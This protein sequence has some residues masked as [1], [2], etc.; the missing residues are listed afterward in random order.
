MQVLQENWI[1]FLA[2]WRQA[3]QF[4]K[5][6]EWSILSFL[7]HQGYTEFWNVVTRAGFSQSPN[8]FFPLV[9]LLPKSGAM[10][11]EIHGKARVPLASLQINLPVQLIPREL[12]QLSLK[13]SQFWRTWQQCP[14]PLGRVQGESVGLPAPSHDGNVSQHV[15][16]QCSAWLLRIFFH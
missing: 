8:L 12:G 3:S 4:V 9:V 13:D 11:N 5:W 14:L 6:K 1:L 10:S 7:K 15:L 2:N 16:K